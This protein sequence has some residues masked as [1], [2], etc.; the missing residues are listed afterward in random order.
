VSYFAGSLLDAAAAHREVETERGERASDQCGKR[1]ELLAAQ[2]V[3]TDGPYRSF[4]LKACLARYVRRG[5]TPQFTGLN[6]EWGDASH[7]HLRPF[8]T[9]PQSANSD[10][11]AG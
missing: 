10:G 9:E 2:A 5:R 8:V 1:V 3:R 6:D 11:V 7:D 4:D